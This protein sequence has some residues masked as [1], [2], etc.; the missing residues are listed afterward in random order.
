MVPDARIK[1]GGTIFFFAELAYFVQIFRIAV[2]FSTAYYLLL[3]YLAVM[4]RPLLPLIGDAYAHAF[5]ESMHISTVH[6][7]YGSN[8]LE[9]S[10]AKESASD[11]RGENQ[12]NTPSDGQAFVHISAEH[13]LFIC[14]FTCVTGQYKLYNHS[15]IPDTFPVKFSPPPRSSSHLS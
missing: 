4:F 13:L 15:R 2:H 14:S 12:Q 7:K 10:L 3:L 5:D 9:K 6:A 11:N 1:C 8:H